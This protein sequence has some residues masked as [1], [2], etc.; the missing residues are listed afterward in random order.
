MKRILVSV[1]ILLIALV[2]WRLIESQAMLG[3]SSRTKVS[4]SAASLDM[5]LNVDENSS[6][7]IE[8]GEVKP[9][10]SGVINVTV[11]NVGTIAG[12]FCVEKISVPLQFLLQ[13]HG[14]CDVAVEPGSSA[15]FALEW[16]LPISTH[17]TGMDGTKFEFSMIIRFENG[18][19]VTKQLTINGTISDPANTPT[20][21]PTATPTGT[22]TDTMTPTKTTATDTSEP[23]LVGTATRT[24][25]PTGTNTL[26]PTEVPSDTATPQETPT[27][28]PTET[29]VPPTEIPTD[30]PT[31][32]PLPPTEV[33]TE[34]PTDTPIG[35]F[36]G[37]GPLTIS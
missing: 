12:T 33:P 24:P 1:S 15:P 8:L 5:N 4:V 2:T 18:Y 21:T 35:F 6:S 28:V 36:F 22:L 27:D 25:T 31:E 16:S 13:P 19:L 32:T 10:D 3:V 11:N 17:D 14:S 23:P 30:V 26:V 37:A 20:S 9:G 7:E 29:P 34:V